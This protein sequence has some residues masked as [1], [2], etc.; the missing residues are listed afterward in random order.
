MIV[1]CF[2]I[3]L[4]F[5]RQEEGKKFTQKFSLI[6]VKL[7]ISVKGFLIIFFSL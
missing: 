7:S 3:I 5:V 4:S 2:F 1:K 6:K